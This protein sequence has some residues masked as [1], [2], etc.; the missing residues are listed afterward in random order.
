METQQHPQPPGQAPGMDRTYYRDGETWEEDI[1]RRNRNSRSIAWVIAVVMTVTTLALALA[2]VMV[3][4][5]KTFEPYMIV[6]DKSSGFVEVKRPTAIGPLTQDE[7]IT[8]FNVARYVRARET[9][10]PNSIKD[11]FDLAQLLSTGKASNELTELWQPSNPKRPSVKWGT[12]TVASVFIKSVTFP[13]SKTAL[14]RFS[15]EERSNAANKTNNYV[16]VVRF[17]YSSTPM[18]NEYRFENPLGFQAVEYRRDQETVQADGS[19]G[20]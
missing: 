8:M 6:V 18:R 5:L 3:V 12:S 2:L 14:V 1:A 13:N 17:Q 10:D 19:A 16:S 15:T 20:Q 9:Y 4:P 11:N 7:A